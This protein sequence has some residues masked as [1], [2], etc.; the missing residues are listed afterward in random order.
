MQAIG[1]QIMCVLLERPGTQL[2]KKLR[3]RPFAFLPGM[4]PPPPLITVKL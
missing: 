4:P 3:S 2:N 1:K